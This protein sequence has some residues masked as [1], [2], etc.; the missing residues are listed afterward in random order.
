MIPDIYGRDTGHNPF[1]L[2][3]PS[4]SWAKLD[5]FLSRD[6]FVAASP[7]VMDASWA[8][9]SLSCCL[10]VPIRASK[11]EQPGSRAAYSDIMTATVYGKCLS[12]GRSIVRHVDDG[13]LQFSQFEL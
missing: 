9:L 6:R 7:D 3:S 10:R 4:F 8:D 13:S 5:L 12:I 2:S 11:R 1:F